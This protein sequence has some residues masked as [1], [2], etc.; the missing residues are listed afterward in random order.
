MQMSIPLFKLSAMQGSCQ[1]RHIKKKIL[2]LPLPFFLYFTLLLSS[3]LSEP[4]FRHLAAQASDIDV[5]DDTA[6]P[7]DMS[8]S[9]SL[10]ITL[11]IALLSYNLALFFNRS[12]SLPRTFPHI[13]A[14]CNALP[15]PFFP[16]FSRLPLT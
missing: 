10:S 14:Y 11:S 16:F 3:L 1:R 7:K 12:H 4:D 6:P 9:V 15:F 8:V 2:H 5:E 13:H